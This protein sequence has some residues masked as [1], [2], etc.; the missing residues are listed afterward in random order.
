MEVNAA[1]AEGPSAKAAVGA[2]LASTKPGNSSECQG[3]LA[4]SWA[5]GVPKK[6]LQPSL[7]ILTHLPSQDE[8][9]YQHVIEIG[10]TWT[11][12]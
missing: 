8:G 6:T 9:R 11:L 4:T 5:D 1:T 12:H 10:V 7:I 2:L 3:K